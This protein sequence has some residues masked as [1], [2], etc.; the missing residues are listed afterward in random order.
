MTATTQTGMSASPTA[1]MT[2]FLDMTVERP[3]SNRRHG[4]TIF[5]VEL[6]AHGYFKRLK[7]ILRNLTG[8]NFGDHSKSRTVCWKKLQRGVC[9]PFDITLF[10]EFGIP[11]ELCAFGSQAG[12][13]LVDN[14]PNPPD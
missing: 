12:Q 4:I 9:H 11:A 3:T 5:L 8:D 13:L 10:Q 1:M 2:D 7:F 14:L 6:R